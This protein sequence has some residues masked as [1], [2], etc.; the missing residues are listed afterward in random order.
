MRRSLATALTLALVL[1]AGPTEAQL[2][3]L[4]KLGGDLVKEAG[5][6]AIGLPKESKPAES[7][8][9]SKAVVDYTITPER[10]EL[11]LA[12]LAPVIEEARKEA[13]AREVRTSYEAKMQ[14]LETCTKAASQGLTGYSQ[15]YLDNAGKV[16]AKQAAVLSYELISLMSGAKCGKAP[17]K[18]AALIEAELARDGGAPSSLNGF[19][20]AE[21]TAL[22][23]R[24]A[25]LKTLAPFF[26]NG[27]IRWSSWGDVKGW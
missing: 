13:A 12:A 16:T 7:S 11:V 9:S 15:A 27:A 20:D 22:D 6:E 5:R 3:K 8:S 21:R 1:T 23:A 26:R 2:G 18:P 25:Q 14:Q 4:K 24:A 10:A 19:S 17:Y